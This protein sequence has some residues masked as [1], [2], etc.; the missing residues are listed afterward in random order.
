MIFKAVLKTFNNIIKTWH[1]NLT[2]QTANNLLPALCEIIIGISCV[3]DR[4]TPLVKALFVLKTTTIAL[5]DENFQLIIDA[6]TLPC[7][8]Q[9]LLHTDEEVKKYALYILNDMIESSNKNTQTVLDCNILA[10]LPSLWNNLNE[11]IRLAA[12]SCLINI[13]AGTKEHKEAVMRSNILESLMRTITNNEQE[14]QE[15]FLFVIGNLLKETSGDKAKEQIQI[16]CYLLN[17][18]N[19]DIQ[20]RIV[21]FLT[22][23]LEESKGELLDTLISY[24]DVLLKKSVLFAAVKFAAKATEHRQVVLNSNILPHFKVLLTHKHMDI[25]V[26]VM[27]CLCRLTEFKPISTQAVVNSQLLPIIVEFMNNSVFE[28]KKIAAQVICNL[29]FEPNGNWL[30]QLVEN[31]VIIPFCELLEI[32]NTEMSRVR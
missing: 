25:R 23:I 8:S 19:L 29:T 15:F 7:F 21:E 30:K 32:N 3:K 28:V 24:D 13:T 6:G 27:N 11:D 20:T 12:M 9:L 1:D 5:I 2:P 14:M 16:L 17:N 31:D 22:V 4:G 10:C 18:T 26:D